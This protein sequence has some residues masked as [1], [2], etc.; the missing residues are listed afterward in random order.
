MHNCTLHNMCCG[1][2]IQYISHIFQVFQVNLE[3]RFKFMMCYKTKRNIVLLSNV[4]L[5]FLPF[6]G[7]CPIPNPS[8]SRRVIPIPIPIPTPV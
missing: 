1:V 4:L 2:R 6:N 7:N 5:I 8:H 3:M